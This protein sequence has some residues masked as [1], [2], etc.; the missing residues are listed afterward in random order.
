MI[1]SFTLSRSN[2]REY[3]YATDAYR[4]ERANA[5]FANS[6]AL[7]IFAAETLVDQPGLGMGPGP[8]PMFGEGAVDQEGGPAILRFVILGEYAGATATSG[9]FGTH[10]VAPDE[11]ERPSEVNWKFYV[12]GLAVSEHDLEVNRGDVA[13]A[14]FLERQTDQVL[15]ATANLLAG[16][17]YSLTVGANSINSIPVL[18]NAND[19]IQ[20][21]S[22]ASFVNWNARGL[23]PVGTV[24]SLISFASGSFAAQGLADMRRL[25]NNASEGLIQPNIILT[26]YQT[27]ERYEASLQPQERFAGAVTAA[28]GSFPSM[29]FRTI[30]VVPDRLCTS[31]HMFALRVG[32]RTNGIEMDFLNGARFN[33][34][35]WKP[36]QTQNAMVRP[37]KATTNLSI[38]NRKFSHNKATS[39]TD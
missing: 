15:Q 28:D 2:W 36:S 21:L 29:A 13:V 37:L 30:P 17:I 24:P 4:T 32:D 7:A 26:E 33:F 19:T 10:N 31:G 3:A 8:I 35:D 22:G 39:I 20:G 11:N 23:S 5:A 6:P 18:I 25:V 12:H 9:P 27:V 16:D 1:S 34:G 14:N 38:G